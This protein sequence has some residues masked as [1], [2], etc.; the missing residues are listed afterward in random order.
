M[1][2]VRLDL[3]DKQMKKL[4][5]GGAVMVSPSMMG[6]A[7]ECT[8]SP[9]KCAKMRKNHTAGKKY[10]LR[11]GETEL[12]GGSFR[13]FLRGAKKAAKSLGKAT[14]KGLKFAGKKAWDEWQEKYKPIYGP[15]IRSGL[16]Y[17][18]G[19]GCLCQ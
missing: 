14:L 7:V 6:G 10:L 8:L 1:E 15:K 19:I 16:K 17:G 5:M 18:L 13:S 3:S 11:M 2:T 9:S 12:K 4:A